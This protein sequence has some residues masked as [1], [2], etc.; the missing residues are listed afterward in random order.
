MKIMIECIDQAKGYTDKNVIENF[1]L[2][3][4]IYIRVNSNKV[5]YLQL[6]SQ[7]KQ[8]YMNELAE[9][10]TL[11]RITFSRRMHIVVDDNLPDL[12]YRELDIVGTL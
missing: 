6:P 3:C 10:M 9:F 11:N 12:H 7:M 4:P 1:I 5:C 8:E 2:D